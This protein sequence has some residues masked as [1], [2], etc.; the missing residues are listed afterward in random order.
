[1][2][3]TWCVTCS[4]VCMNY[5]FLRYLT[6]RYS[7]KSCRVEKDGKMTTTI[8]SKNVEEAAISL[9]RKKCHKSFLYKLKKITIFQPKSLLRVLCG[10]A[11]VLFLV[12]VHHHTFKW[13]NQPDAAISQV[14]YLSFKYSLTCLGHLHAHHQELNNCC[15]SLWFTVGAWW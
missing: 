6:S 12:S 4:N 13:I 1:M 7:W 15:S 9:I 3:T 14:Y 10:Y 2:E 11:Q 5:W 8:K